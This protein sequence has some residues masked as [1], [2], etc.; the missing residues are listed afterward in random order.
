M[1]TGPAGGHDGIFHEAAFYASDEQFLAVVLPFLRDGVAAGESS[2]AGALR[3]A[4][5]VDGY[6]GLVMRG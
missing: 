6:K 3:S 5:F 2:W 1:R 4:G